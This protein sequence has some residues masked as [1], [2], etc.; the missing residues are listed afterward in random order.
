LEK[1]LGSLKL[2]LCQIFL[3]LPL[4]LVVGC[5]DLEMELSLKKDGSGSFSSALIAPK[6][7]ASGKLNLAR[8]LVIKPPPEN[9][10]HA[11]GDQVAYISKARFKSI[12]DLVTRSGVGLE[13]RQVDSGFLWGLFA[14]TYRLMVQVEGTAQADAKQAAPLFL[15]HF[16]KAVL[17]VPGEIK[18]AHAASL[19]GLSIQPEISQNKRQVKWLVPLDS[20]LSHQGPLVFA[21]DFKADLELPPDQRES[22]KSRVE[23]AS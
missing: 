1:I 11:R 19:A 5:F 6:Q 23:T 12:A 22:V 16:F 14:P 15:G 13:L 21:V 20:F 10:L 9:S 8:T 2:R 4:F 3:L 7:L 17:E 18:V